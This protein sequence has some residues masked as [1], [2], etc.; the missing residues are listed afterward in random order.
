MLTTENIKQLQKEWYGFED[1]QNIISWLEDF[2]KWNIMWEEDFWNSVY[3]KVN[4]NI[5]EKQCIV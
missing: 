5:K 2:E 4:I 3:S 1:I